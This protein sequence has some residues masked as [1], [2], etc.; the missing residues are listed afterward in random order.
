MKSSRAIGRTA[1]SIRL[2]VLCRAAAATRRSGTAILT[3]PQVAADAA[4]AAATAAAQADSQAAATRTAA[5]AAAANAPLFAFLYDCL[6]A[7][8]AAI[9]AGN[10]ANTAAAQTNTAA[11]YSEPNAPAPA[12][13]ARIEAAEASAAAT[14]AINAGHTAYD[15]LINAYY[16]AFVYYDPFYYWFYDP[17]YD[18]VAAQ[19]AV[20]NAVAAADD[21][22]IA[23]ATAAT[24]AEDAA[25]AAAAAAV[26]AAAGEAWGTRTVDVSTARTR[27][28]YANPSVSS[29]AIAGP[30]PPAAVQWTSDLY[31]ESALPNGVQLIADSEVLDASRAGAVLSGVGDANGDGFED[32]IITAQD[33][34]VQT[35]QG[36]IAGAGKVFLLYGGPGGD[37]SNALMS[38][39]NDDVTFGA[40]LIDGGNGI[41]IHGASV[42]EH[43]GTSAS[44]VGDVNGDGVADFVVGYLGADAAGGAYLVFGSRLFPDTVST[45]DIGAADFGAATDGVNIICTDADDYAGYS[46][47]GAGD[48]NGDGFDDLVVGAPGA[49]AG[50]CYIVFG[51][52][53]GIGANGELNVHSLGPPRGIRI[54]GEEAGDLFGE[55]VS[56][57]GDLNGD[58]VDDI[59]VGAPEAG[60]GTGAV[61]AIFG[62]VDYGETDAP[63]PLDLAR[64]TSADPDTRLDF[65]I[66]M[67]DKGQ[68]R[69]LVDPV[70]TTSDGP[71]GELPGFRLAGEGGTFGVSVA[72]PGD[73]NGDSIDDIAIGAPDFDGSGL[74]DDF[75]VRT[76]PHWGRVYV[77]LGS[78]SHEPEMDAGG[79][80]ES[81][82]GV[83]LTGMDT[84]DQ[85]GSAVAAAGDVN[86]DGFMDLLVG[87]PGASPSGYDGESYVLLGRDDLAGTLPLRDLANAD[88]DVHSGIYLYNTHS[89]TDFGFGQSVSTAGDFNSD[90]IADMLVGGENGAFLL[91]GDTSLISATYST[92]IAAGTD[93]LS[94]LPVEGGPDLGREVYRGVGCAG[95]RRFSKPASGVQITF[96]GGGSGPKLTDPSIQIVSIYREAAPDLAVGEGTPEDDERWTPA[97]VYWKVE[98]NREQFTQSSI[99][100]YYRPEDVAGLDLDKLGIF[101]AK[102]NAALTDE[103]V[104]SWLPYRHDPDRRMFT[105]ER[106]HADAD[107]ARLEFN[108]YYA[109]IQADLVTYLGDVIPAVG[110]TNENVYQYGPELTPDTRAFWHERDKK[111]YA[112][113]TGEL[114]IKWKN[115]LGDVVSEVKAIN[116]WPED[117]SSGGAESVYQEYVAGSPGVSLEYPDGPFEFKYSEMKDAD[118]TLVGGVSDKVFSATLDDNGERD[119]TARAL[120][121]M[122]TSETPAQGDLFFQFIRV[123]N[124]NNT[125][126]LVPGDDGISWP[127]GLIISDATDSNYANLHDPNAGGPFV[128]FENAAYA[129]AGERYVGFYDRETREGSIVPVNTVKPGDDQFVVVYYEKGGRLIE[130]KTGN[131][132]RHPDSRELLDVFDWPYKPVK[133]TP[134]WPEDAE[135]IVIA[136]QDGSGAIDPA[137]Y[138]STLDVYYQNSAGQPGYN[139]NEEHAMI[140]LYGTGLAVFALRDDLNGYENASEPYVLMTYYDPNDLTED[141]EGVAKML[142]FGVVAEQDPYLFQPSPDVPKHEDPYEGDVG[143]FIQP[144]YPLDTIEHSAASPNISLPGDVTGRAFEDRTGR[145]WAIS[146]GD[147]TMNFYYALQEGFYMP[148]AYKAK[149]RT[150]GEVIVSATF[151]G[152]EHEFHLSGST[153]E[154]NV[155]SGLTAQIVDSHY[156]DV[157]VGYLFT[158]F[159]TD[160]TREFTWTA[161]VYS[162]DTVF[163]VGG[164]HI[165]WLDGGSDTTSI[166]PA[167]VMY[168]EDWPDEVPTMKLSE[169][170]VTAKYGLPQINGQCSVDILYQE[171][172]ETGSGP[173]VLLIDPVMERSVS[174]PDEWIPANAGL[175]IG[176]AGTKIVF[177]DLPPSL[178]YRVTYD[179]FNQK[180]VLGGVLVEPVLGF[181]YVLLN[182]LNLGDKEIL[183]SLTPDADWLAAVQAL[184]DLAQEPIAV[185]KQGEID[186]AENLTT[187]VEPEEA[188]VLALTSGNA[189]GVGYVTLAMQDADPCAPLPVSLEVIEVVPD[190]DPG[191]IAVVI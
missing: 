188:E 45:D 56:G 123:V 154:T 93:V 158:M 76:E 178:Q 69:N 87:A 117:D 68:L 145:Y 89:D 108:G 85:A 17:F 185:V 138:G 98:T 90:T 42:E 153:P 175:A 35:S 80:G 61:Y 134:A 86:G 118:E 110:V 58:G 179:Q 113:E 164:V 120:V 57:A 73:I 11:D 176:Y 19:T 12:D 18:S 36:E 143:A 39:A 151:D 165:P 160:Q 75:T 70:S 139:P 30:P 96:K 157:L 152:I 77:V 78:E 6:D 47:A 65:T 23:A 40:H 186:P 101:Y 34:N 162:S 144:P 155:D 26:A 168:S 146:D 100:F 167:D 104:W 74:V 116:L 148:E 140:R 112:I 92:R 8:E 191:S 115:S 82:P 121:M 60:T 64:L 44:G 135:T 54:L 180:L 184:Y 105:V 131:P 169:T 149:L 95:D 7:S 27:L 59:V 91:L 22:A 13:A 156:T 62:H 130:A 133:Y 166:K 187:R 150:A 106:T 128:L 189:K 3:I 33:A 49:G 181:P 137:T 46:V 15:A 84:T 51:S 147:V 170:L 38:Y 81:V 31:Y 43:L 141:D 52:E 63:N 173:S 28:S 10:Y 37:D 29:L 20:D 5:D 122:S 114:T 48:F 119:T 66:V 21:A 174:L 9:A 172:V 79:V 111:L 71:S 190:L 53:H 126:R 50:A 171:A 83:L 41:V 97:G 109:L 32:F 88:S 4:A 129:P 161:G 177:T 136:R 124:W 55:S 132:V 127:V 24:A 159:G 72:G 16:R 103:T 25:T 99:N 163:E 125:E 14:D 2:W 183:D 1:L 142:V 182:A 67:P 102:P 107:E 94:G